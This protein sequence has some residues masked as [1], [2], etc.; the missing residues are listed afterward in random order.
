[1][2]TLKKLSIIVAVGLSTIF[3][4]GCSDYLDVSDDL[5]AELSM[6]EVFNNTGY[7]RRFHRY[8]YSGIPDVSNIIIT[9]SYAALTGLDNPWPAVSDELKSAQNNVKTIPTVGYHAGRIYRAGVFTNKSVRQTNFW[10]TRIR[11]H[12]KATLRITLTKTN[13]QD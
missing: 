9:S 12:S 6:E 8:I 11:S 3:F 10:H 2:K 13:W 1:M 5:A 4:S 7:A